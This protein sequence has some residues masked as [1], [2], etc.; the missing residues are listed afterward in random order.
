M[1]GLLIWI[2]VVALIH[3]TFVTSAPAQVNRD[4][5][6]IAKVKRNVNKVGFDEKIQVKLLNGTKLKGRITVIGD[7]FFVLTENKTG[8]TRK[9]TFAEVKQAGS[10]VDNP[11]NDPATWLGLALLP[12]IIGFV[13]WAKDK[14]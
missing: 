2:L 8:D 6:R 9:V 4:A 7:E 12:T 14:D 1:R 10:V 5:E 13:I 3:L 11:F